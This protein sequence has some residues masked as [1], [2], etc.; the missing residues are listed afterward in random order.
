MPKKLLNLSLIS[1]RA[2]FFEG[3]LFWVS[4]YDLPDLHIGRKTNPILRQ[5]N[6]ILEQPI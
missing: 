2:G 5:L 3:N 6:T 1:F 4:Q